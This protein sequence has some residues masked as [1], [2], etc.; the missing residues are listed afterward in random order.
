MKDFPFKNQ[1]GHDRFFKTFDLID[2][3]TYYSG[4]VIA[5]IRDRAAEENIMYIE[6]M[7]SQTNTEEVKW[8]VSGVDWSDNFTLMRQNLLNASLAE[9]CKQKC[10]FTHHM[11]A[12]HWNLPTLKEKISP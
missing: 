12:D 3:V 5:T 11:I 2:P 1:S 7:T 8:V 4:D 6:L 9:I 10:K